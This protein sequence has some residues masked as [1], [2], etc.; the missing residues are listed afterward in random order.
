MVELVADL[1]NG[2]GNRVVR[3]RDVRLDAEADQV[4]VEYALAFELVVVTFDRGMR[5]R[6]KAAGGQCLWVRTPEDTARK[7]V[8]DGYEA[9]CARLQ[10][11]HPVVS[12]MRKG[13][14]E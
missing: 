8:A 10:A 7:R 4:L 11:R 2:R 6:V 13:E 5:D 14:V 1:L 9:I 3:A 12:V